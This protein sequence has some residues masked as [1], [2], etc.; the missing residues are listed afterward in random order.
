MKLLKVGA[1]FLLILNLF[2]LY[3]IIFSPMGIP[4]LLKLKNIRAE[5]RKKIKK[6]HLQ[7]IEL[8]RKIQLIK[9]NSEFQEKIIRQKL[10]LGKKGELLYIRAN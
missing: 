6:L 2:L 4:N 5:Y 9:N 1:I 8:S 3:R 10:H 7:N